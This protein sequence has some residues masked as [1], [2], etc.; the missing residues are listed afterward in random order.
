M[1]H[2]HHY[3]HRPLDPDARPEA[4]AYCGHAEDARWDCTSSMARKPEDS[5]C[6]VC[7]RAWQIAAE[8]L[9]RELEL[10]VA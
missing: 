5:D 3:T 1:T 4:I 10:E 2:L 6:P 8:D 9:R 7:R